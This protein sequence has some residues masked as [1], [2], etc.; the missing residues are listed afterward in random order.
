MIS[1]ALVVEDNV[2]AQTIYALKLKV[3]LVQDLISRGR[4]VRRLA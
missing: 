2:L 4:R 3:D 1:L